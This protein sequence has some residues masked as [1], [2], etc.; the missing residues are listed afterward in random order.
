MR[1]LTIVRRPGFFA[2]PQDV[3]LIADEKKIGELKAEQQSVSLPFAGKE[4]VFQAQISGRDGRIY[5]SNGIF[6]NTAK[7]EITLY[8]TVSGSSLTLERK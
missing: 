1:T 2:K 5:R 8:L 4:H 6:E 3:T 7:R